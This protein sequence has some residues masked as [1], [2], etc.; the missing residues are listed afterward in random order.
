MHVFAQ[1]LSANPWVFAVLGGLILAPITF[2]M[3]D[4]LSNPDRYKH[5]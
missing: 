2:F 1:W 4:S 5:K 3:V